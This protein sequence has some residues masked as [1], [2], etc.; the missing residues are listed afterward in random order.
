MQAQIKASEAIQME[1]AKEQEKMMSGGSIVNMI[2]EQ[3]VQI[4]VPQLISLIL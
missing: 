4:G 3:A 1:G 2:I